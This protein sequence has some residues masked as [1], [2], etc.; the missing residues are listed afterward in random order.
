VDQRLLLGEGFVGDQEG[1]WV[2]HTMSVSFKFYEAANTH[3]Y[4]AMGGGRTQVGR[5]GE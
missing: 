4:H 5:S 3:H 1:G 2:G